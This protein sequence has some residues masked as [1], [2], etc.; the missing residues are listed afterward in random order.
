MATPSSTTSNQTPVDFSSPET[1][2][3]GTATP[4]APQQGQQGHLSHRGDELA[5]KLRGLDANPLK[6][7]RLMV[8]SVAEWQAPLDSWLRRFPSAPRELEA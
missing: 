5:H 3:T 6:P 8:P 4:N 2:A 1:S 7:D